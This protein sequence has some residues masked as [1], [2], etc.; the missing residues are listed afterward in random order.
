MYLSSSTLACLVYVIPGFTTGFSLEN[1]SIDS[2]QT[3]TNPTNLCPNSNLDFTVMDTTNGQCIKDN[4]EQLQ[5]C[6]VSNFSES[7]KFCSFCVLVNPTTLKDESNCEC[8]KCVMSVLT[9]NNCFQDV[10]NGTKLELNNPEENNIDNSEIKERIYNKYG[11]ELK[12]NDQLQYLTDDETGMMFRNFLP[13]EQ[14]N[15]VQ[16]LL[17]HWG[18]NSIWQTQTQ[19]TINEVAPTDEDTNENDN[20]EEFKE[21]K[22]ISNGDQ[23]VQPDWWIKKKKGYITTTQTDTDTETHWK[24]KVSTK[25]KPVLKPTTTTKT[26]YKTKALITETQTAT[27]TKREVTTKTDHDVKYKHK[28]TTETE[29]ENA[30][31]WKTKYET[32]YDTEIIK[33]WKTKTEAKF[34]IVTLTET[35]MKVSTRTRYRHDIVTATETEV[36]EFTK[37]VLIPKITKTSTKFKLKFKKTAITDTATTTSVSTA[38]SIT[39]TTS[40]S[41]ATS[42]TTKT[43]WKKK[44]ISTTTHVTTT[45]TVSTKKKF[46]VTKTKLVT[47]TTTTTTTTGM[48]G[49]DRRRRGARMLFRTDRTATLFKRELY[50]MNTS[51]TKIEITSNNATIFKNIT[52]ITPGNNISN[53][54]SVEVVVTSG[55]S[56]TLVFR[57]V[58]PRVFLTISLSSLVIFALAYFPP[59]TTFPKSLTKKKSSTRE[60]HLDEVVINLGI[61]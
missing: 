21:I 44:L 5:Q 4:Y 35:D 55:A 30:V 10:C 31:R 13:F 12:Q 41:T 61:D 50:P 24:L 58:S 18:A 14:I 26:I 8:V 49:A 27:S 39:T 46:K 34:I 23:L 60:S 45:T 47:T 40:L 57:K 42:V 6:L 17:N 38:T 22:S 37:T 54:S 36:D 9:N 33:K 48:V 25:Y 53:T 32:E 3:T 2:K 1:V 52:I 7:S 28:T 19:E 16:S 43:K 59:I 51:T 11:K 20:I 15:L 29:I 56:R